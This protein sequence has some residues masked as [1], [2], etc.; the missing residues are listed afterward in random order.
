[1]S[2]H[3]VSKI[4]SISDAKK[5]LST[6]TSPPSAAA[7]AKQVAAFLDQINS[8]EVQAVARRVRRGASPVE[9]SIEATA[10]GECLSEIRPAGK[11]H[12]F[13]CPRPLFFAVVNVLASATEAKPLSTA[14]IVMG[15]EKIMGT[16]P[17]EHQYGVAI[18]YL[19]RVEPQLVIRKK[20]KY[21]PKKSKR[22]NTAAEDRWKSLSGA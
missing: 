7:I 4:R 12:A 22:L 14:D 19:V 2:K 16:K 21:W 13:R 8:G 3:P 10:L 15:V 20:A 1:M 6:V 9:Y 17:A 18:R 5:A 11:G